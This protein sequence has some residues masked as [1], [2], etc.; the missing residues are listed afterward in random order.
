[1][2]TFSLL[3]E[4]WHLDVSES[5]FR[6]LFNLGGHLPNNNSNILICALVLVNLQNRLI[7]GLKIL[8]HSDF[9]TCCLN[10][11]TYGKMSN[12]GFYCFPTFRRTI[13]RKLDG[14]IL[15]LRLYRNII[16][17]IMWNILSAIWECF[18]LGCKFL[19]PGVWRRRLSFIFLNVALV[20]FISAFWWWRISDLLVRQKF[21]P[22]YNLY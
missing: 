20:H 17:L 16:E 22:P 2:A 18:E 6:K 11:Q 7:K 4:Y 19:A 13:N 8:L 9:Q 12:I 15:H 5:L 1:M 3:F 10:F 21:M 14:V